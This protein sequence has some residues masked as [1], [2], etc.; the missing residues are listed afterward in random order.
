[1]S[2]V[3]DWLHYIGLGQYYQNF[4]KHGF[5]ELDFVGCDILLRQDIRTIGIS[6]EQDIIHLLE[7]LQKKGNSKGK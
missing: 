4:M 3:E 7:E 1:L 6:N 5:D 2:S